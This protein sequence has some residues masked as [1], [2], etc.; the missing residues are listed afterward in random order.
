[1]RRVQ[2]EKATILWFEEIQKEDAELV[3]GKNASLGE[4]YSKMGALGILV[5]NGFA[6]TTEAYRRFLDESGLGKDIAQELAGL[7]ASDVKD[8]QRRGRRIRDRVSR[9]EFAE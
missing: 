8:L 4:M 5:P 7:N 9:A 3:G 6:V 2:R 1:M